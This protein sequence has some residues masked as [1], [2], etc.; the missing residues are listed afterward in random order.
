MS[1]L[2]TPDAGWLLGDVDR[3]EIFRSLAE[4]DADQ[5]EGRS[6]SYERVMWELSKDQLLMAAG[7]FSG[8]ML[9]LVLARR[10]RRIRRR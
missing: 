4:A 8:A 7:L 2:R 9:A 1:A 6:L 10:R 3:E 5:R